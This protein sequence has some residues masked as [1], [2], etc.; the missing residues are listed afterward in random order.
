MSHKLDGGRVGV[1]R[2]KMPATLP[3]K[4]VHCLKS[5]AAPREGAGLLP[6]R[7][8]GDKA[9]AGYIAL[10]HLISWC[11]PQHPDKL[12]HCHEDGHQ[13]AT[14]QHHEDAADVLHT[15]TWRDDGRVKW[16]MMG[17]GIYGRR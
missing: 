8:E 13:Q 2:K 6:G 12:Q 16:E 5:L 7:G 11:L 9:D 3:V 17:R 4:G 10:S 14:H 15:Q 1:K